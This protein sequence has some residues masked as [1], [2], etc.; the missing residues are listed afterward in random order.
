M[1]IE[2]GTVAVVTGAASGI[3]RACA[4]E[5][6]R[7]GANVVIADIHDE[8][9]AESANLVKN[10]GRE[11][12]TVHCD[13]TQDDNLH[14]LRRAALERF[15][16]VDILMNNAGVALMGPPET[17]PLDEWRW[18]F[19][20]NIFGPIRGIQ[21]FLPYFQEQGKGYVVNTASIAGRYAYSWDTIPYIT[22]KFAA[23]GLSEGLYLYLKAQ[24]IGVSV[25][26]PGLVSTNLGE[27]ARLRGTSDPTGW[28]FLP[29][30]LTTAEVDD[31]GVLVADAIAEERFIIYTDPGEETKLAA[32]YADINA[33]LAKQVETMPV[34]PKVVP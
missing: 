32:R 10:I 24:G 31:V 19:D 29:D 14:Q 15:G 5:F 30:D 17:I 9:M 28:G 13:V 18:I 7:R 11:A 3:G 34:P 26:C 8:R 20:I 27:N 16:K 2:N 22:S 25:L 12:I 33:A 21:A 1:K 6:A 23:Y 4:L